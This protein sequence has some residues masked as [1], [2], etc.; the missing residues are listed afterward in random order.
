MDANGLTTSA[1]SVGQVLVVPLKEGDPIPQALLPPS[2]VATDEPEGVAPQ[3]EIRGVNGAGDFQREAVRLLN[4]GGVAHMAG[5]SLDDD[6]ENVYIFP[7]FTLHNGAVSVHT[8][9]GSD[10][11]IDLYWGLDEAV[12]QPGKVITLR[13]ANGDAQSTFQ[14]PEE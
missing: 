7:D 2:A 13:D 4:S 11:V 8:R 5:W 6:G 12:W 3:V 10:T 1:L 9:P 14:I